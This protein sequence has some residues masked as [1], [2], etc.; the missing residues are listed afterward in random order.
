MSDEVEVVII[1]TGFPS[2]GQSILS[3]EDRQAS[4]RKASVLSDKID[5]AYNGVNTPMTEKAA[6]K[7]APAQPFGYVQP[8]YTAQGY[9][10]PPYAEPQAPQ[11]ARPMTPPMQNGYPMQQPYQ[12]QPPQ[13]AAPQQY[14]QSQYQQQPQGQYPP[15][16]A[17]PKTYGNFEPG[18]PIPEAPNAN[19]S[20]DRKHRPKFVDYFIKKNSDNK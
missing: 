4:A 3:A 1:A 2:A 12:Q 18:D 17:A 6:E 5:Q 11:Q 19:L 13:Y 9:A 15:Q 20:P 7:P 14:A 16:Y 10:V 8:S